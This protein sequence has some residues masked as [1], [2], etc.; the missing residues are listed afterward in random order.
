MCVYID[1]STSLTI[2]ASTEPLTVE[3]EDPPAI[4]ELKLIVESALDEQIAKL[5]LDVDSK[6][7]TN[8]ELMLQQLHGGKDQGTPSA[9]KVNKGKKGK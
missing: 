6:L 1:I 9:T 8:E 2:Q 4:K 3:A 7:K 5:K